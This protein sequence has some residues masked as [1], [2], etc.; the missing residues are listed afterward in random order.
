MVRRNSGRLGGNMWK[1]MVFRDVILGVVLLLVTSGVASAQSIAGTVTDTTGGVLPGVTIEVRSPALIEQVRA[2]VSDGNGQYLVSDLTAGVYTVTFS[3]P[4]FS[5]FVR[6]GIELTGTGTASVDGQMQVGSVEET[7]TVTGAAPVVDVQNVQ[8]QAVMTREVVDTIPTGKYFN[9]LGVLVPGMT[10]GTTYGVGQDVGGQSGQSHQRMSIH[11]GAQDDQRIMVDG[12][13]MSPWTQEDAALVWMAD[14]NFEEVQIDHSAI[15]AEVETGGVRFNLIPRTGSNTFASRN[16]LNFSSTSFQTNNLNA[17]LEAAGLPEP[18][19]LKSLWSVN[20]SLGGPIVRDKLWFFGSYTHQVADS[21]VAFYEDVDPNALVFTPNLDRQ[22][23]DDQNVDDAA[24]RLTWQAT[25]NDKINFYFDHNFNCHCHFLIG[26]ALSVNVQPSASVNLRGDTQT[27]QATWTSTLSNRL[28]FELGFSAVPQT[29]YFDSQSEV[30]LSLPGVLEVGSGLSAHRGMAAWYPPGRKNWMI[31]DDNTSLRASLSYVTGS[32]S[33]KFGTTLQ[34]GTSA[35]S[36]DGSSAQ[37][38]VFTY[39]GNPFRAV[40]NVFPV[41]AEKNKDGAWDTNQMRSYGFYAQDQWTIDRLTLNYGVRLDW[42]KG[43]YP[44]HD[45]PATTWFPGASFSGQTVADWKDL[46]PRLGAVYDLRGDGRTALKVTASR[47]IDGFGTVLAGG[48]NPALQ[49]D[50]AFYTWID[51]MCLQTAGPVD[52]VAGD[53]IAQGDPRLGFPN[54]ELLSMT[55]NV[56]FGTPVITEIFD[57]NWAFGMGQR[58]ANWEFSGG[59]QHELT[60]G[61]SLNVSYFNRRF[62]NFS[63]INNRLNNPED[64]DPYCVTVP[65]DSRLPGGGGN[66]LCGFYE[67]HADKF[68]LVDEITTSAN[69]FGGQSRSWNGVDVTLDARMADILLQGGLSTGRQSS[70]AC[71]VNS[72]TNNPSGSPN[73]GTQLSEIWCATQEKMLTQVKFLGSYMLPYD[74]QLAG[75]LQSLPGQEIQANVV[76][77]SAQI[78]PSLGRPIS[79]GTRTISVIEPGTVYG[80]RLLQFDLR[81]TKILTAGNSRTQIMFDLYNVFNDS[82]PL[83]LNNQYAAAGEGWMRPNL[84]IP[85]RLAKFAFQVDF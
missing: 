73:T 57:P 34:W 28:L 21:F 65:S 29:E 82:T 69:N 61:M 58:F 30:D 9:N 52:C 77:T 62:D 53:G 22:A 32:H 24:V 6:D 45:L 79:G 83:E 26:T 40:F 43:L 56:N 4:G 8:Q 60:D 74:I 31:Y 78:E 17:D 75:T 14:G 64:Y 50:R 42:F 35:R 68:G 54:G 10:T 39:Y 47:Y 7:I 70:D 41:T 81:L 67:V 25:S 85:G 36:Q 37:S 72:Q 13:S 33:T 46:N 76:Y 18:N 27:Y 1:R 48:I 12:M 3:L 66:E 5:T 44:D 55:S 19:R 20:P 16:F 23:Y 11:G 2:A 49:N 84:I 15:T 71:P 80:D 51:N 63:V 59:I 38:Q